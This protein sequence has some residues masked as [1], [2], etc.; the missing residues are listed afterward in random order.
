MVNAGN[1][2][3]KNDEVT[4]MSTSITHDV[5]TVVGDSPLVTNSLDVAPKFFQNMPVNTLSDYL[6]RLTEIAE[7]TISDTNTAQAIVTTIDP[8]V[9]FLANPRIVDKIATYA[10]IRGTIE[11]TAVI[12][13]PGNC[14]GSYVLTAL[15]NG[16]D[17]AFGS[18][19]VAAVLEPE[20]C[21]QVDH[22]ARLDCANSENLVLQLPFLWPFD[23][24][25]L[26]TGPVNSWAVS[27]V[28]LAP[29]RT[30]I[31]G[32]ITTG[33]I[34]L[35][36][37]LLPDYS[38]CVPHLQGGDHVAPDHKR[39]GAL[40]LSASIKQ[41]SPGLAKKLSGASAAASKVEKV[42]EAAE[43]IP[44]IGAYAAPVAKAAHAVSKVAS[45]FGFTRDLDETPPIPVFQRSTANLSLVDGKDPSLMSALIGENAISIDP[46][47]AGVS[48][49]SDCLAL[50]DLFNRWTIVGGFTWAPS[51]ATGTILFEIPV[52]PFFSQG[53]ALRCPLTTAGWYG[54]PFQY[55]RGD[56][57]YLV[58]LPVS[59]LHRGDLQALWVPVGSTLTATVTNSTLNCIY[60]VTA[61]GE[62]S[63]T[64]GYARHRP[65]SLNNLMIPGSLQNADFTNGRLFLRVIN[66]LQSQNSEAFVT[67]TVF[68]RAKA[69]MTFAVPR[70]EIVL[71]DAS[72]TVVDINNFYYE[73]ADGDDDNHESEGVVLVTESG[74]YPADQLLFGERIESVR[75]LLQKPSLINRNILAPDTVNLIIPQLGSM[76]GVSNG[77]VQV[78]GTFTYAGWYR[79]AFIGFACSERV[80]VIMPGSEADYV[81]AAPRA[82]PQFASGPNVQSML[83]TAPFT[84][85]CAQRG[86]EFVIP[87]YTP[88]KFMLGREVDAGY[89]PFT[90]VTVVFAGV[91]QATPVNVFTKASVWHCFGPDIRAVGF[92]QIPRLS[93]AT[94]DFTPA[95]KWWIE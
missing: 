10:L 75:A 44:V 60:D 23:F 85:K 47:M 34:K 42:A 77:A 68:A 90:R 58:V 9:L 76:P 18:A 56:M 80:K 3:A 66:P 78:E 36:A 53:S 94:E 65:F 74:D 12:A 11:I 49:P 45:W 67:G 13:V 28:C 54:L 79:A 16:G 43:K 32:G 87:Y 4:T 89:T 5:G 27:L 22:Y 71:P 35:F 20:N 92:R 95:T 8:W 38:I 6:L 57:E 19:E 2:P 41:H 84:F 50:A 48:G 52:T 63:F 82:S 33:N 24:A 59:K 73:G 21:M 37:N 51:Q 29:L 17:V 39:K 15:P 64:V 88:R 62:K 7:I 26:P 46:T 81:W 1:D 31:P 70:S 93:F 72:A 83:P 25:T 40:V 61:G 91:D 30:A 86:A 55:W 14:Y 69:N